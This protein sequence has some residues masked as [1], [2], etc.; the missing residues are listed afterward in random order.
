MQ[1]I[2]FAIIAK[3]S[4]LRLFDCLGTSQFPKCSIKR[5]PPQHPPP[6]IL[7]HTYQTSPSRALQTSPLPLATAARLS[8]LPQLPCLLAPARRSHSLP[9]PTVPSRALEPLSPHAP[10]ITYS[11]LLHDSTFRHGPHPW[12]ASIQAQGSDPFPCQR[13]HRH[14]RGCR[15]PLPSSG[16]RGTSCIYSCYSLDAEPLLLFQRSLRVLSPHPG[17]T[18]PVGTSP[19]LSYASTA[20]TEGSAF[21][22]SPNI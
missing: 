11:P 2:N 12:R 4:P 3:F 6:V 18:I 16:Y 22:A 21:Q 10:A 1:G 13:W 9:S 7:K 20:T 14:F 8:F 5:P 17:D 19:P 15:K